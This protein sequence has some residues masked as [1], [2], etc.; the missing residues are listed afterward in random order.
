MRK[1]DFKWII[2]YFIFFGVVAV[3]L[4]TGLFNYFNETHPYIAGFVQFA[5]F[6]TSGEILSSRLLYDKWEFNKATAFKTLVWGTS[7]LF[8]TLMFNVLSMGVPIAMQMGMLPFYGNRFAT[9]IFTSILLNLF[10][11][12]IHAA[13]I[14]IFSSYGDE[15]FLNHRRMNA[16]EATQSIEWGEFVDFSFFKTIPFFWIP[17]N[18]VGFLL[19]RGLQVAFAAMLS[20]VFGMLMAVLKLR[21][22]RRMREISAS[23]RLD[24]D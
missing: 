22:R 20:F 14:R 2:C 1:T 19:P 7:G 18:T 13:A 23:R 5:L 11:A 12:P 4:V 9:A 3:L 15:R 16:I 21:E 17:I 6:A 8:V 10:F 24:H